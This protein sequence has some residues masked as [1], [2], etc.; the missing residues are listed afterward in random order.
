MWLRPLNGKSN[1][2]ESEFLTAASTPS[3]FDGRE[4]RSLL[5]MRAIGS[6]WLIALMVSSVPSR[7]DGM[8]PS[9]H[10]GVG[11]THRRACERIGLLGAAMRAWVYMLECA[12]GRYYV[13]SY[14]GDDPGVRE[15]EHNDG[16][17]PDA[18]TFKRRPVTL[19]WAGEFQ[20][21]TDAI[22]FEQQVK[23]WSRAKK[24]AVIRGDWTALPGL[25]R[26]RARG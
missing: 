15:S 23:R 1:S 26:C 24:E 5:T 8:R 13:G 14:R 9:N 6:R 7:S 19:V 2:S 16:K 21:I 17:F 20:Q 10:A 18:W 25:A 11:V 3:W 12:D 4:L 22:A